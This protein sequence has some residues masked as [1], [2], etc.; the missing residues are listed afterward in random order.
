MTSLRFA[1]LGLMLF[2]TGCNPDRIA[3]LEKENKEL[4][5]KLDAALK[6]ANLELQQKCA[7]Q[8]SV[9][10]KG[11]GWERDPMTNITNHYNAKVNKCFIKVTSINSHEQP[12]VLTVTKTVMDAFEG[13]VYGEYMWINNR[14]KQD[15]LVEP[16]ECRVTSLSGEETVC[17]SIEEFESWAKQF[18]EQ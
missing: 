18:M 5:A 11:Q 9:E 8:S 16:A 4:A 6:T 1:V 12:H 17:N 15:S 3:R 7:Q 14:G 13:K 10:F 2:G